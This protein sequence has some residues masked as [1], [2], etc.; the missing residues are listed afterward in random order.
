M[1][2]TGATASLVA[3]VKLVIQVYLRRATP[4][5]LGRPAT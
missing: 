3:R 2:L 4:Q 5:I 1:P